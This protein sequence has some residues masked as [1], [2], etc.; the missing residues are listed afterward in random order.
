MSLQ[1]LTCNKKI[2]IGVLLYK[3]LAKILIYLCFSRFNN[4]EFY[5][6]KHIINTL[7]EQVI[8]AIIYKSEICCTNLVSACTLHKGLKETMFQYESFQVLIFY[9]ALIKYIFVCKKL[10]FLYNICTIISVRFVMLFEYLTI[11]TGCFKF[12]LGQR[13]RLQN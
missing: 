11:S 9:R 3:K 10:Y 5:D 6:F 2:I 8:K 4:Y 7:Q 13:T 1:R 12:S